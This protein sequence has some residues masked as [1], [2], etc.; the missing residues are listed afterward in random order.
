[1]YKINGAKGLKQSLQSTI[2][3][4][5][6]NQTELS[7]LANTEPDVIERLGKLI[8][9]ID[10]FTAKALIVHKA[11]TKPVQFLIGLVTDNEESS[12]EQVETEDATEA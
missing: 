12:P 6:A 5:V 2:G 9:K 10:S 7:D 8:D 1:M 11:V 4:V 3:M